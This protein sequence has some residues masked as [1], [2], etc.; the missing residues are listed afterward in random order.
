MIPLVDFSDVAGP[1]SQDAPVGFSLATSVRE[2]CTQLRFPGRAFLSY[3]LGVHTGLHRYH[4][5]CG[6][7]HGV[8]A[9]QV[10]YDDPSSYMLVGTSPIE[11]FITPIFTHSPFIVVV[12]G[13]TLCARYSPEMVLYASPCCTA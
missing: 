13:C 9:K 7:R 11:E 8:C 1:S 12:R 4:G 5:G 10:F 6:V 2:R 3:C